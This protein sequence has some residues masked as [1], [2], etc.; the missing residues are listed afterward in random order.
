MITHV[1]FLL[2][3]ESGFG[4]SF[5]WYLHINSMLT[6][7]LDIAE[8]IWKIAVDS[9]NKIRYFDL[10]HGKAFA[11]AG[12]T[13]FANYVTHPAWVRGAASIDLFHHG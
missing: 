11:S 6:D 5:C 13:E 1:T 9:G 12:W 10:L 4:N 7:S 2:L 8:W 3:N